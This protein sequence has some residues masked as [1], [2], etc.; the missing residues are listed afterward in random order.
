MIIVMN[1]FQLAVFVGIIGW[2]SQ[3]FSCKKK[4]YFFFSPLKT[5]KTPTAIQTM[6]A[7]FT[8]DGA[9][10]SFRISLFDMTEY[11]PETPRLSKITPTIILQFNLLI[12]E[13]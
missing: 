6:Q 13:C 3:T 2:K 1:T 12:C 9:M 7:V 4:S 10:L 8:F 11:K 5:R